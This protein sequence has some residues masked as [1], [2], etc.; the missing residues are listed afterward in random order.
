MGGVDRGSKNGALDWMPR[1]LDFSMFDS[2]GPSRSGSVN[3][4]D[5]FFM[6]Q[7]QY[8]ETA[9][10]LIKQKEYLKA[11]FIYMKLLKHY[12][13]AAE[14]LETG[15]HYQEAATI[16]LKHLNSKD[17]AARCYEKGNMFAE[18]IALYKEL[19]ELEKVG[20]LYKGMNKRTEANTY[21][22]KV[23]EN[24]AS[25][26]QYVKASLIYKHKIENELGGQSLLMEG[27]RNNKDAVNCLNNY[28]SNIQDVKQLDHE[29]N[30]IYATEVSNDNKEAF[31]EVIRH[32]YNRKNELADSIREMAYY[33]IADRVSKNPSIVMELKAFN[34]TDPKLLKDA[35]TFTTN[36]RSKRRSQ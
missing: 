12:P 35:M 24:Y 34:I 31:L 23:V 27:W 26:D 16:Y 4:G 21:Y 1:W 9:E 28:F 17:K 33:I 11:A 19:N 29:I 3:L 30:T 36:T 10:A 6:L 5:H 2:N 8:N 32:E 15:G 18:A 14:T 20:D 7:N 22:E 25:K 13:K